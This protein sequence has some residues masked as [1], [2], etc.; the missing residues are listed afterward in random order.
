MGMIPLFIGIII[1]VIT[2]LKSYPLLNPDPAIMGI[3]MILSVGGLLIML[4]AW[5]E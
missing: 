5:N 1:V 2:F 4:Y 3:G